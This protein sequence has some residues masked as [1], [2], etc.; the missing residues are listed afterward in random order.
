MREVLESIFAQD[1][2]RFEVIVV[3]DGSTDDSPAI[4]RSFKGVKLITQKNQGPAA[5]RNNGIKSAKGD[6]YLFQDTDAKVFPGWMT[7]HVEQQQKGHLVVGGSVVPWNNTL[8]GMCDHYA[9]WYEYHP[10]KEFQEDR[11]QISSTNL[12]VHASVV[13]K[14]GL[15]NATTRWLE[16]VDYSARL[17]A[18]GFHIAFD[19]SNSM[20]HHDRETWKGFLYHHYRYGYHAP[21]VR[22]KES[23]ARFSG[24]IPQTRLGALL[25][26]IPLGILHTGF[27]VWHWLPY[28]PEVVLYSPFIFVSKLAHAV[29]VYDGVKDKVKKGPSANSSTHK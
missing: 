13:K 3:D 18:N 8:A 25:M 1:Y 6:I 5:A 24:L 26:I 21:F 15:F 22:T 7:K 2:P 9:T 23:G 16:D 11:Y 14:V 29:G 17:H 27:T 28:H 10:Q 20:A 12:S 19:P 4:V